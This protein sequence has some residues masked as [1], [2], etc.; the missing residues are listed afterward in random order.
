MKEALI[1]TLQVNSAVPTCLNDFC[2]RWPPLTACSAVGQF[3]LPG[4]WDRIRGYLTDHLAGRQIETKCRDRGPITFGPQVVF[5]ITIVGAAPPLSH[6][7][8]LA[9]P[10]WVIDV[11]CGSPRLKRFWPAIARSSLS[12]PRNRSPLESTLM[13][14][15]GRPCPGARQVV[16]WGEKLIIA[17]PRSSRD[18]EG[19]ACGL[20]QF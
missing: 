8:T 16:A 1:N 20:R 3:K 11:R 15:S 9:L 17:C 14:C 2:Q 12:A 13:S 10:M 19:R 18:P 7:L 6:A 5:A 4:Y